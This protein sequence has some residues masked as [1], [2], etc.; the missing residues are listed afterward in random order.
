MSICLGKFIKRVK[1][2][3][4]FK[5]TC[6]R[7]IQRLQIHIK[8]FMKKWRKRKQ[9]EFADRICETLELIYVRNHL[10]RLQAK[11][12]SSIITIQNFIRNCVRKIRTH[13]SVMIMQWNLV[14]AKLHR[15]KVNNKKNMRISRR[16][17]NGGLIL[18]KYAT[19]N[20]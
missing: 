1:R 10:F 4:R 19:T 15:E 7:Y 8:P 20:A 2:R 9:Q 11:W 13:D 12:C 6:V 3:R 5:A 16:A 17:T 14:E 18:Y